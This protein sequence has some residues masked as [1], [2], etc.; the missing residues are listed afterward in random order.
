LVRWISGEDRRST[1]DLRIEI[2]A[3]ERRIVKA[4]YQGTGHA[5]RIY[6][7]LIRKSD[8]ITFLRDDVW[9]AYSLYARDG[10]R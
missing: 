4:L 8:N 3:R 9:Q 1:Q 10:R 7:R 6:D 2:L 5:V